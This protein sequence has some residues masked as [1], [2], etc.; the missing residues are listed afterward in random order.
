M[1]ADVVAIMY[2]VFLSDKKMDG[3]GL[4]PSYTAD[5]INASNFPQ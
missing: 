2:A 5:G 4:L 3:F 1:L